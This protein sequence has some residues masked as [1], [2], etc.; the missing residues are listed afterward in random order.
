M[1]VA[2]IILA[3]AAAAFVVLVVVAVGTLFKLGKTLDVVR[4]TME[5]TQKD[6]R[7]VIRKADTTLALMNTNLS[8]IAG[9]TGAAKSVSSNVA[10]LVGITAASLG[11]PLVKGAAFTFGVRKAIAAKSAAKAAAK[12][13]VMLKKGRGK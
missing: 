9:V 1:T 4:K 2:E 8:N 11:G 12:T 3:V 10:G 6:C 5:T 7:P 13:A